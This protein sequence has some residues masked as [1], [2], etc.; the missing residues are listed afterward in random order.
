MQ[1]SNSLNRIL[2]KVWLMLMIHKS[3]TMSIKRMILRAD[4]DPTD[5]SHALLNTQ[6]RMATWHRSNM[7]AKGTIITRTARWSMEVI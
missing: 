5:L 6:L 7:G 1:I 3:M 4:R 2:Q